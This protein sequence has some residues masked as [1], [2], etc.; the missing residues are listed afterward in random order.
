MLIMRIVTAGAV[1]SALLGLAV[2]SAT[3]Q[4]ATESAG[5]P[6]P[7]L[8]FLQQGSKTKVRPHAKLRARLARKTRA[9]RHVVK[10][11]GAVTHEAVAAPRASSSAAAADA[12]PQNIWPAPDAARPGAI[13][14]FAPAQAPVPMSTE[15]VVETDP[16]E[17]VTGGHSAQPALPDEF[18]SVDLATDDRQE[19][20]QET[21]QE[22]TQETEPAAAPGD[23]AEPTP[24]IHADVA[25]AAIQSPDMA[26]PV[27]SASWIAQALAALAGA[28]AAG[29]VAWF[30]IRPAPERTYG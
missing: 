2:A 23:A 26:S 30:L 18:N 15:A 11:T 24:A 17:I 29:V 28:I 7:L 27:G 13:T 20:F 12:L 5:K 1:V 3:A 16:N 6:L 21:T 8:Q 19:A 4:G 22:T 25:Q 14:T 9:K 10:R